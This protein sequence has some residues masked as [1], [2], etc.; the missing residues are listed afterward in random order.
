MF[1][2]TSG[3]RMRL[4][5]VDSGLE[6]SAVETRGEEDE[7]TIYIGPIGDGDKATPMHVV[8][9]AGCA[10][11]TAKQLLHE[12]ASALDKHGEKSNYSISL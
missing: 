4:F 11:H 8:T 6:I 9:G 12:M 3:D 5:I 10:L 2:I 7:Y 1:V